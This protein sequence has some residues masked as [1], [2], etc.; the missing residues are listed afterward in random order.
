MLFTIPSEEESDVEVSG[1]GASDEDEEVGLLKPKK[2]ANGKANNA[3]A[4]KGSKRK[5]EDDS[6]TKVE[7]KEID[8]ELA[9]LVEV[10]NKRRTDLS[11]HSLFA[12]WPREREEEIAD[13]CD[14]IKYTKFGSQGKR[15]FAFLVY[16]S[17]EKATAMLE[18]L[19]TKVDK[20]ISV[21]MAEN[22]TDPA[23]LNLNVLSVQKIPGTATIV[24]VATLFPLA[25]SINLYL[26]KFGSSA[27]S[28][29]GSKSAFVT[30]E[31]V[32]DCKS[33]F[34]QEEHTIGGSKITVTFGEKGGRSFNSV[35]DGDGSPD[36]GGGNFKRFKQGGRGRGGGRGGGG[37]GGRG[38]GRGG[39][40][41][42]D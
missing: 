31:L 37:R 38:R 2:S 36:K 19:S 32:E 26:P 7:K 40:R 11:S 33:Y 34:R 28:T 10:H 39:G 1:S 23:K 6:P 3:P 29:D 17:L 8:P 13:L 30:F 12:S 15:R 35:A 21:K 22:K 41:G 20:D 25:K 16:D 18:I 27:C 24:D 9:E 42:R 4:E 14:N 5:V